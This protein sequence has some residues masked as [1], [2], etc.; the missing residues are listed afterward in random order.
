LFTK[1]SAFCL[2]PSHASCKAVAIVSDASST[3]Y[4]YY[5]GVP[6]IKPKASEVFV[7]TWTQ[8][9]AVQTSN[10]RELRT[11]VNALENPALQ[12]QLQDAF[13]VF[14][15]DNMVTVS[16]AN[17]WF[18]KGESVAAL[19][20]IFQ[21]NARR[22]NIQTAG[23]HLPGKLNI[24]T[25]VPSRLTEAWWDELGPSIN[26]QMLVN[27]QRVL[28]SVASVNGIQVPGANRG[29]AV[30]TP[31]PHRREEDINTALA[32][33]E[34]MKGKVKTFIVLP[35]ADWSDAR[36]SALRSR[37]EVLVDWGWN[38]SVIPQRE[39]TTRTEGRQATVEW[40]LN[41]LGDVKKEWAT[42]SCSWHAWRVVS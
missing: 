28:G 5:V 26:Q 41:Q 7:G 12:S 23:Y 37:C 3:G 25:D 19:A 29:I 16:V 4:A 42:R 2:P 20:H 30:W 39:Q 11:I 14:V 34:K 10:W 18:S 32:F 9:Q 31:R 1:M 40:R 21:E 13:V 35:V 33:N 27:I 15:S 36:W 17:Y 38:G 24:H 22:L 8:K 6:W